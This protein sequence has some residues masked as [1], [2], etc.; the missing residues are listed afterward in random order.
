M[1][2]TALG[3]RLFLPI[4]KSFLLP[5]GKA[6]LAAATKSADRRGR[7]SWTPTLPTP[8]HGQIDRLSGAVRHGPSPTALEA[9]GGRCGVRAWDD[10]NDR[11]GPPPAPSATP[12]DHR[13]LDN[14]TH[15]AMTVRQIVTADAPVTSRMNK[16]CSAT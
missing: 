7:R 6:N 4:R 11:S 14:S 15:A 12:C 5:L 3:L 13:H 1:E 10:R 2:E 8:V 16:P 9:F